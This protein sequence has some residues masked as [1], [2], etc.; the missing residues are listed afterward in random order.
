LP[1]AYP[2]GCPIHPSYP[3]GHAVVA[4]ACSTVLKAFFNQ[5]FEI[6]NPVTADAEGPSPVPY[7]E[8]LRVGGEL[9]KLAANIAMA[10]N[11]A[12]VHWR[13]DSVGGIRLGETV[14]LGLLRDIAATVTEPFAGFQ[15]TT[16]DGSKVTVGLPSPVAGT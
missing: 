2:E 9:N 11:A 12:G 6:P 4:G 7:G 13:S 8:T 10:R 1:L 3:A 16:F 5:D 15:V 14:A